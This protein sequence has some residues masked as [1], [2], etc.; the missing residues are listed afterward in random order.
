[1][2][3]W[4]MVNELRGAQ[5]ET[6]GDGMVMRQ[7]IWLRCELC[8]HV[9]VILPEVLAQAVGYDCRLAGKAGLGRRMKCAACGSRRV[10]VRTVGPGER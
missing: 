7:N 5:P 3:Y 10:R 2:F 4:L 1:M 8:G 6:L 9:A